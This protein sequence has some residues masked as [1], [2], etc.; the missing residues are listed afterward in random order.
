METTKLYVIIR[1][2]ST[3]I[4]V[5]TFMS[6]DLKSLI[7]GLKTY[8]KCYIF[9]GFFTRYAKIATMNCRTLSSD[10]RVK[11]LKQLASDMSIDVLAVQE[12]K[13]TSLDAHKSLLLPGRQLMFMETPS[14]G[15]GGIGFLLSPRAVK[16]RL[17]FSFPSH[18]IGKIVLD[19]SDRCFHVFCAY[20]P[21]AVN[22]HK[23]ECRTF[24]DELSS[25]VIDIPLR[26]HILICGDLNAP[27]TAVGCRVK[28]VCGKPNSN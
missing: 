9:A 6:I 13:R 14:P 10:V 20:A 8:Y 15:V 24:H 25:L 26:D 5:N 1:N 3:R 23:A 18:R 27:L 17:F 11:E 2:N 16:T 12:H 4:V 28:N 22:N 21:T 19:D 7:S